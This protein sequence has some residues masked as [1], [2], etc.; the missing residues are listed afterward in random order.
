MTRYFHGGIAGLRPGDVIHAMVDGQ[1]RP[2]EGCPCCA[3]RN[4]G[5]HPGVDGPPKHPD[6]VY[7]TTDREYARYYAS[8]AR[9]GDLYVVEPI[10]EL[11]P[12]TEDSFPTWIVEWARVTAVYDRAVRLTPTQRRALVRRWVEADAARAGH[13]A[14][15]QAMS[16]ADRRA[17]LDR[18]LI[19]I[20][21]DAAA[22]A[23][24]ARR[25]RTTPPTRPG[26]APT[27][28]QPH[29]TPRPSGSRGRSPER[30]S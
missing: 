30:E 24:D 6:R 8:V 20:A 3:A 10:G 17:L 27:Q 1:R 19:R 13:L 21:R 26:D 16:S 9:Y 28:P 25:H 15:Y 4:Q 2:V 5:E 11:T 18:Q 14:Q 23:V 29:T 7:V 22:L 12:S